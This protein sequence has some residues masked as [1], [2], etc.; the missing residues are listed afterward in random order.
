MMGLKERRHNRISSGF[1]QFTQFYIFRDPQGSESKFWIFFIFTKERVSFIGFVH[2]QTG[3]GECQDL[4]NSEHICLPLERLADNCDL[5]V[6]GGTIK[7]KLEG[8][9]E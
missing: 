4:W 6:T 8:H 9:H 1:S 7:N 5:T 2:H 3:V